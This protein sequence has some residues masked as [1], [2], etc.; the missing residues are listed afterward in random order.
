MAM[1]IH[2]Y[3]DLGPEKRLT[4]RGIGEAASLAGKAARRF[5]QGYDL[6]GMAALAEALRRLG[7]DVAI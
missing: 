2:G 4:R 6:A 7:A 5:R 1:D 3:L